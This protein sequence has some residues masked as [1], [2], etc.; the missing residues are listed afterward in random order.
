MEQKNIEKSKKASEKAEEDLK[1]AKKSNKRWLQTFT[2][3]NK[4]NQFIQA[5]MKKAQ[6][7]TEKLIEL[8]EAVYLLG[9]IGG[10]MLYRA[11][12]TMRNG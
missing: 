6:P 9:G 7:D 8:G 4:Y 2:V 10:D 11:I 1:K 5:Q 12:S 3:S